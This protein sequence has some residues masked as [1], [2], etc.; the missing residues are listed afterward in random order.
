MITPTRGTRKQY[1]SMDFQVRAR[2]VG[3]QARD[4]DLAPSRAIC[5]LSA[6]AK[7]VS[8]FLL[9]APA[10]PPLRVTPPLLALGLLLA[11]APASARAE[12]T[13]PSETE[14]EPLIVTTVRTTAYT[15][16]EAD[17]LKYGKK[18]ALGTELRYS[19]EY[20]SSAADWSR[21][22]LGTKFRIKGYDRLFVVDD[23]GKAL[24][25]SRT[26]DIYFDTRQ[27]MNNWGVRW[28]E[29][30]VLEFGSFHESRKILASRAKHPHCLA[31]LA[32]MTVDDWWKVYN[33]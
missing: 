33:R 10:V 5:P 31:M 28:V 18:T 30:E 2:H 1:R 22:P 23:Y 15:H 16:T 12:G 14:G 11:G 21:F 7:C 19:P 24:T 13:T 8:L 6:T 17:H 9:T 25:G 3:F 20:H 27:R 29:I 4:W 32:S 26:I